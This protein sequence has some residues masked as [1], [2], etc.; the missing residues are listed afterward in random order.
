MKKD[1]VHCLLPHIAINIHPTGGVR[2]C[3]SGT[4]DLGSLNGQDLKSIWNSDSYSALRRVRPG[5]P[6]PSVCRVC[7]EREMAGL[8]S[9]REIFRDNWEEEFAGGPEVDVGGTVPDI[10][11]LDIAVSNK[12]NMWC[13]SCNSEFSSSWEKYQA[14]LSPDLGLTDNANTGAGQGV[15]GS[16]L[17]DIL[18]LLPYCQN[19]QRLTLKGGE[20]F[21]DKDSLLFLET[22]ANMDICRDMTLSIVTNASIVSSKILRVL[23]NFNKV[24]LSYSID[25]SDVVHR[26]LRGDSFAVDK[27]AN[28][29]R[30]FRQLPNLEEL[31][32][33]P[34]IQ[35]Y[36]VLDLENL[37][38]W[39][40]SELNTRPTFY[41]VLVSP[42]I[43]HVKV[44][45]PW[46]RLEISKQLTEFKLKIAETDLKNA[47]LLGRII[48]LLSVKTEYKDLE[49][50]QP[51]YFDK[52]VRYT[53]E[54]DRLRKQSILDAIPEFRAFEAF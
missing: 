20:P 53:K 3:I 15:K 10:R 40:Q 46:F 7:E 2:Q 49:H 29:I 26:Y 6:W 44:L 51:L 50:N 35:V 14:Q 11:F 52:F 36:N 25:G 4:Q 19:L 48:S 42:E 5:D 31:P 12:C 24:R 47:E 30:Q 33:L 23:E 22:I 18:S 37:Y 54:V 21:F 13:R 16:R 27:L 32:I 9:R 1:T 38:D 41:Q 17:S 45:P 34:T 8:K 39:C 28:N 43:L